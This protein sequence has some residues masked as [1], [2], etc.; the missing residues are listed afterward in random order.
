M[1][2]PRE[3]SH[4]DELLDQALDQPPERRREW[5]AEVCG[6][7]DAL[8]ERVVSLLSLAEEDDDDALFPGGGLRGPIWEE[9]AKELEPGPDPD[10]P[11]GTRLGPYEVRELLGVG[12]MGRVFRAYDPGL[13]R[14]VAIKAL[15]GQFAREETGLRRFEREA[16]LLAT[17]SHPSIASIYGF[18]V[19]DG[20][21]YLVL[22][23]VEGRTLDE[24][25]VRHPL[26][27]GEAVRIARQI[28]EAL[29]EAHGKGIVHRDLKP[30]NVKV[31]GDGRVKVLDFGL[32]RRV[33]SSVKTDLT[34]DAT[35]T[36]EGIVLGT[37]PYMSPEQ[38]RGERVDERTDIWA[39]GC[40]LYEMITGQRAFRGSTI[41]DLL[42]A[43]LRDDVDLAILPTSTPPML[44]R[45]LR[46]CLRKDP[47]RRYRDVGDVR[48][49][50]EDLELGVETLGGPSTEERRARWWQTALPWAVAATTTAAAVGLLLVGSLPDRQPHP[51]G[52]TRSFVLDLPPDV[53]LPRGDYA[54]PV[55]LSPDGGTLVLLGEEGNTVRLYRRNLESLEW[56]P[57]PGTEGAWQP[58]FSAD[59]TEVGFFSHRR[60]MR[61]PLDGLSPT[62]V[63]ELG[64]NP[65]GAAWA[66]DGTI[67]FGPSQTSGL[68][69][70]SA[71]G[72]TP[73]PLTELDQDAGERSHRWPQVLPD[74][75]TVLFTVDYKDQTFDDAGIETVSLDTGQRRALMRGGAHARYVAGGHIIYARAGRLFAAPFDLARLRLTGSPMLVLD[76]VAYDLRNGG[77]KVAVADD[78]TLAY[79]PGLSSE[80][81][82]RLVWIDAQGRRQAVTREGRRFLDPRLSP[83]GTRVAVRIGDPA[84]S[85]VWTLDL[86]T[87]TLAQ[88]TFGLRAYRPTWTPD[89]RFLTVGVSDPAGWR[90]VN[91]PADGQGEPGTLLG[92]PN[93]LYPGVWSADGRDL[94]YEERTDQSGWD[95]R[96]LAVDD[97]GDPEGPA[98]ALI[99]TAANETSP[100]LSP[101]GRFLAYESDEQDGLVAIYV[102]PFGRS[103]AKVQVSTG[104]GRWPHWGRKGELFYWSSFTRQMRRV[105][106]R[107]EGSRFIVT[108]QELAWSGRDEPLEVPL[109]EFLG[110]GFDLDPERLRFLMLESTAAATNPVAAQVILALGWA[111]QL[112]T[113]ASAGR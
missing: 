29:E 36:R 69:K 112:G 24:L 113:R 7:D 14:D 57:L 67:L 97:Q 98:E 85:D 44:A 88:V 21:S 63:T 65:R 19:I 82:R 103:G 73:V 101:D 79:V 40:L 75:H 54:P 80:S 25:L 50:L 32:A 84:A 31:S 30:S 43:V 1:T 109:S 102:R 106:H 104:G 46:R 81:D 94:V 41:S 55:A 23:L 52:E 17:L 37:V 28:A 26:S 27:P 105:G 34:S 10:I 107:I 6:D 71:R 48:I 4:L 45:L 59:G 35:L 53:R 39:L 74:G 90:L 49:E 92:S 22:E 95:L 12:G 2:Q 58:F 72:G 64:A 13:D 86:A 11:P 83:D 61:M 96:V 77:T 42:A 87:Q 99:A 93:R 70:V 60:L 20:Q 33:P 111:R 47:R 68:V 91:V 108:T 76:G 110:R 9:L 89:G 3:W 5:V 51:E 18:H 62:V 8:R 38:A 15:A 16:K 56:A 66:P 78:G 100:A